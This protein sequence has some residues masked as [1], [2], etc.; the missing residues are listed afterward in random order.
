MRIFFAWALI[1]SALMAAVGVPA[2]V[3]G[4]LSGDDSIVFGLLSLLGVPAWLIVAALTANRWHTIPWRKS[5]LLNVPAI[6]AAG[7][8]GVAHIQ[9][10]SV[11]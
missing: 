11:L 4:G 9:W 10:A 8:Y 5:V 3:S 6:A 7:L 1:V 2:F